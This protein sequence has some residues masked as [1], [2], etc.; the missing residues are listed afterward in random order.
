MLQVKPEQGLEM[1]KIFKEHA[2]KTSILNDFGFYD[3]RQKLMRRKR[4]QNSNRFKAKQVVPLLLL[5]F[6]G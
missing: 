3:N 4:E 6:C 1:L 5:V 2:S